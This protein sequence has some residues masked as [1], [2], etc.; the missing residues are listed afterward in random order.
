MV[1]RTSRL[2]W[3]G[4]RQKLGNFPEVASS[5]VLICLKGGS[6][7]SRLERGMPTVTQL[8]DMAHD[9]YARARASLDPLAKR[10]LMKLADNYLKQAD[11]MRRG[12]TVIKAEFPKHD[13]KVG[14][15]Q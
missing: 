9:L 5:A 10:K 15:D 2:V 4:L 3:H 1:K 11:D 8:W 13:G 7:R 14:W 6:R 12:Q